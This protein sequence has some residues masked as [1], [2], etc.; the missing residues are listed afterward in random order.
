MKKLRQKPHQWN[1][2]NLVDGDLMDVKPFP[3]SY[4]D[5]KTK[6]KFRYDLMHQPALDPPFPR[7]NPPTQKEFEDITEHYAGVVGYYVPVLNGIQFDVDGDNDANNPKEPKALDFAN[8][9]EQLAKRLH[10][11]E[12]DCVKFRNHQ[13][14]EWPLNKFYFFRYDYSKHANPAPLHG[15]LSLYFSSDPDC[16]MCINAL[17]IYRLADKE[18]CLK[19][20]PTQLPEPKCQEPSY[21]GVAAGNPVAKERDPDYISSSSSYLAM[22]SSSYP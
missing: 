15:E 13:K 4:Q 3:E 10:L 8:Y 21:V 7:S 12:P 19:K 1:K 20:W 11:H 9:F 18:D 22:S 16:G 17:V 6:I 5:A 2:S 14:L